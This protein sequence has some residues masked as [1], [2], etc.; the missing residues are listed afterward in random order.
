[1]TASGFARALPQILVYEGGYVNHPKD[2][3]GETNF[4]VIKRVYDAYR[5]GKDLPL[6]SVKAITQDEVADIYRRQYWDAVKGD[7]LPAGVDFVVFDGAVNSGPGQSIRWLQRVLGVEADGQIGMVTMAALAKIKNHDALVDKIVDRR[8]AF[9]KALKTFSTFGKGWMARTANVRK[10]GKQWATGDAP[11]PAAPVAT[12][13]EPV[14]APAKA[15]VADATKEPTNVVADGATGGGLTTMGLGGVVQTLQE[16]LTPFSMAGGWISKLVIIL[17]I[18]GALM[19]V[20][21]LA[22][23]WWNKRRKA[24]RHDALDTTAATS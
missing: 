21:G 16:Q 23:R 7:Q 14:P 13:G 3:G 20:G 19:T 11:T 4:G 5:K 18:A 1:M 15:V 6:R 24:E 9:L 10:L 22:W 2:P 12:V 8:E 17:I